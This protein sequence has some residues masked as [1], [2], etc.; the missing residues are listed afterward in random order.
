MANVIVIGSQWGDEGKGKLVDLLAE[1]AGVVV[2]YQGGNNAGHTVKFSDKT[3][4]LHLIPS[5]ILQP[6]VRCVLGNGMVI[7]P[8]ALLQ[9]IAE[10]EKLGVSMGDR[11]FIS[12]VANLIMPYH[13]MIDKARETRAGKDKIG[14]T[15]R[16]IGPAYED[17]ASREGIRFVEIDNDSRFK[18]KLDRL[19]KD[20][21]KYLKHVLEF[22]GPFLDPDQ[23]FE[24]LMLQMEKIRPYI[25]DT[26]RLV[27]RE[28][29]SGVNVLFEGAQGT[30]LDVD[31]GTYPFV[32]SSNTT[33]GGACTGSGIAPNRIDRVLGVVKA[34]TTRVGSGPF[35]T[36]LTDEVGKHLS[37]VGAEF[38][39]TTGRARR[40][41]W[42]DACLL[43]DSVRING[44]TDLG[45]TKM[46]VLD[47]LPILKICT[48]Y[49]DPKGGTFD[50]FPH[51]LSLQEKLIPVYE[52]LP[53][54]QASTKGVTHFDQLPDNAKAYLARIS[55]LLQVDLTLIS[56]GP[57]REETIH[58]K[59]LF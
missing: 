11:L 22:E 44:I 30:F 56:T 19:V 47:G 6:K 29:K 51:R 12:D 27:D 42:F 32:T 16:G 1:R 41:G 13:L 36:E 28:I 14:T 15:S 20:K 40:C 38:G 35:P 46:D 21:N 45:I 34:Y 48:H 50:Y 26:G 4:I 39:A 23:V 52:E 8:Q 59:D 5:G 9:E 10:L 55:E 49:Q 3:F 58:L 33:S 25:A 2:R 57:K 37:S 18:S 24:E 54:W 17:K 53:G 31:H 7:H 43:K